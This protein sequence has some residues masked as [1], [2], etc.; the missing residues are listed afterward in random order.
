VTLL[1]SKAFRL[2]DGDPLEAN[3]LKG[4]LHFIELERLDDRF[5]LFHEKMSLRFSRY[6]GLR[7]LLTSNARSMPT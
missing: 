6:A 5:D 2:G 4:F 1:A 3:L 7:P